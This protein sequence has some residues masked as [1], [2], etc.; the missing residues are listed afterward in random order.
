MFAIFEGAV[1]GLEAAI[2]IQRK[3]RDRAWPDGVS[4]R[5][6]IGL[7]TG[8]PTLT[9]TGYI[10]LAVHTASRIC[11]ASH[12]GQIL[13]SRAVREAVH[14]SEPV[15]I[16]F[17]DLGLHQFHG[18]AEPEALFQVEAADLPR[19]FPPPRTLAAAPKGK[20]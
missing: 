5:I 1:S 12:G 13:L 9:D 18:L 3:V 16:G 6:R 4:V 20:T 8:R 19:A 10:G 2:S 17:K 11:F 15:G 7:H 14:G